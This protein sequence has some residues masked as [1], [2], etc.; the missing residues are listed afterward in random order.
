MLLFLSEMRISFPEVP[1][2]KQE[3]L[4]TGR[5]YDKMTEF[6]ESMHLNKRKENLRDDE[7][8]C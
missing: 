3:N 6:H 2:K 5:L 4:T 1:M 7:N 8:S